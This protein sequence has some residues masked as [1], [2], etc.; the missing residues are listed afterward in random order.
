MRKVLIQ[1]LSRPAP[2]ALLAEYCATFL[3]QLRG[4]MFRR[5]IP[6]NWGLLLVGQHDSR[7][8]SSIHMLFMFTDLAV[9]WIN[10]VGEVVDLRLARCWQPALF[11]NRPARYV[12]EMNP[13]HLVDFRVGDRLEIQPE[14]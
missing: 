8:G 14:A 7:L 2:H 6:L 5:Y 9:V 10:D 12:L 4:L 11:S 13:E 3:C 1:N